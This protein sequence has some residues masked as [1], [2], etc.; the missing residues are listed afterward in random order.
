MP[1]TQWYGSDN[2]D[3]I[4]SGEAPQRRNRRTG[5]IETMQVDG[6]DSTDD[7]RPIRPFWPDQHVDPFQ[8]G[9]T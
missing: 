1:G 6:L 5:Q 8:A 4:I 7:S 9:L 2:T 3:R